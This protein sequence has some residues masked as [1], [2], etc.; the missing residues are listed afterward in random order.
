MYYFSIYMKHFSLSVGAIDYWNVSPSHIPKKNWPKIHLKKNTISLHDRTFI[1]FFLG[2]F[3]QLA[4]QT[5]SSVQM[6]GASPAGG[7]AMAIMTVV[8]GLTR[9]PVSVN[10][11]LIIKPLTI[12]GGQKTP[13]QWIFQDFALTPPCSDQQ[14]SFFT[15][16][17]RA[18]FPHYNNTKI[19]KF[20]WELLILWVISYG[21]SF[22]GFARFPEFRG[23]INDSFGRP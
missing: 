8:I 7:N 20:G 10:T 15:L 18:S 2:L 19:V 14:L 12:P 16:L 6:A 17:G 3:Q 4:V 13:E 21:L 22:S 11:V 9:R 23:T 1:F 5:L